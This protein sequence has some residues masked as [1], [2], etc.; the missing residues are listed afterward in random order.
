MKIKYKRK[1][2]EIWKEYLRVKDMRNNFNE[3]SVEWHTVNNYL[4]NLIESYIDAL[5]KDFK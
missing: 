5:I 3:N 4:W 2:N 1:S